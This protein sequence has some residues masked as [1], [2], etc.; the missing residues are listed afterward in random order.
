M[1]QFSIFSITLCLIMGCSSKSSLDSFH[2][3]DENN[4]KTAVVNPFTFNGYT[5]YWQD[6]YRQQHRYANLYKINIPDV[7]K[8][9]IQSKLDI[10][11]ALGIVG[12][13]M[14]EG[15]F[16]GLL[17]SA[18][19]VLDNPSVDELQAALGSTANILVFADYTSET[20]KNLQ[21]KNKR[22]PSDLNSHQPKDDNFSVL[23]AFMLKS[24]KKTLYVAVGKREELNQLKT[25]LSDTERVLKGYDLKRGWFG[26]ETL[27]K[28]VTCTPGNPLDVIGQGMN[29][30]NSWF[31][32]NGYMDFLAKDEI[33]NWINE[34]NIPIVTDVGSSPVYGCENYDGLQIQHMFER[35]SWLKF[36]REKKGYLFRNYYNQ[37]GGR[38]GEGGSS[39]GDRTNDFD[40]Y[41]VNVGNAPQINQSDKPF[42][43]RTGSLL[44]GPINSMILFNKK[45]DNF[46][47][48]KMWKAIMDRRSVAV[49]E[50]G[51]IIGPDIYRKAIQLLLLDKVYIE[52]Y[53]GDRVN[54]NAVMEGHQLHVT[55]SNLYP[56][57]IKG[58]LNVKLPEQLSLSGNQTMSL[59]LPANSSKDLVF[60]INPSAKA[61]DNLNAVV[62]QYDWDNSSKSTLASLNLPPAISVHQVLY[63]ASSGLQFPVTIHN[64]T[65]ENAVHV[66][67]TMTEKEDHNKIVYTSEQTIQLEKSAHKTITFD[68][69]Q[70]PGN[71]FVKTEA[72]GI[73]AF[74]QLGIDGNTGT[75]TL[76]EVDLNNDGVNEYRMENEHVIVT[77]LTTGAR[78]IEYIVKARNDN[79]FFKLWPE[80]AGDD[81][82]PFRERGFYP[83]GGF[84]DFLGQPSIETHKIYDAVVL[85]RE[86]DYVQVKMNAE[87][88]GNRIEK[89]FTLYGNSPL[90][91]VRFALNMINP[92]L[93]VLGPQPILVIGKEHGVE[94]KYFLPEKN[95]LHEMIMMPER[96]YGRASFLKE[97]WNAGYDT[98]EDISFVGAFPVKRLNFL[99]TFFNHPSNTDAR[100]YYVEFQPW[101][102]L[103]LNTTSYFSYYMWAAAG[104]W[105][106]SLQ[107]LRNRN[108]I[109]NQ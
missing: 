18:Y 90:L 59:Q 104:S 79:V 3:K 109:T 10:A 46:N 62:V 94:D 24:G 36:A 101:V 83:F 33:A 12:L 106:K 37:P 17:T 81:D 7:E 58:M 53:F 93:N 54:I 39:E 35:D 78:V 22:I 31:V 50:N 27:F 16:N 97:G 14:Q 2:F 48:E 25:I 86:G 105:E 21:V 11:E 32:F 4:D 68:I 1:K 74:T 56:H 45:G 64:I 51:I 73:A 20:G 107:E 95:G 19:T 15:F 67:L 5:T 28:S 43:N 108:L 9:I 72:M 69:K 76:T 98:K 60:E 29:E 42:V 75:A 91:E 100:H 61:M 65:K 80:K 99:H 26:V 85:K 52:E 40:G 77:L 82:R 6:V 13:H 70:N 92:E 63:G 66:K 96:Y 44:S 47:Q 38:G 103:Y 41:F 102:R 57:N 49:A 71:Y 34:V 87:Y 8:S 23:D 84:E 89:I 88:Y 55:I 30:G